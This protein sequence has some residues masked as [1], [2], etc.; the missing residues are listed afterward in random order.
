MI[1]PT[2]GRVV[3][4]LAPNDPIQADKSQ[5]LDAHIVYVHS[6]TLINIAGFNQDGISFAK[7]SVF[8]RADS[9][10]ATTGNSFW[11]EW[12]PYQQ[13]QVAKTDEATKVA[14]DKAT[15]QLSH[16]SAQ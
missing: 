15:S 4:F 9:S 14:Q 1:K 2:V 10:V 6:D 7:T 12:M 5:P 3:W 8:L 16:R 11:C 13:G